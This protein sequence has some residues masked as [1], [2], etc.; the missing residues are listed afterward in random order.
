MEPAQQLRI[1]V[2]DIDNTLIHRFKASEDQEGLSSGDLLEVDR[3]SYISRK[4]IADVAG[5]LK[6]GFPFVLAT[7]RRIATYQHILKYIHPVYAIVEDGCVI[8]DRENKIDSSWLEHLAEYVGPMDE[9]TGDLHARGKL[10]EFKEQIQQLENK[11]N[12]E[13]VDEGFK[14]S[15]KIQLQID[16]GEMTG[17]EIG[18]YLETCGILVPDSLKIAVN[19]KY[20]SISVVPRIAGKAQAMSHILEQMNLEA[21]NLIALGDD[22][23]DEELLLQAGFPMTLDS[24]Q[25]RIKKLVTGRGGLVVAQGRHKGT[26]EMLDCLIGMIQASQD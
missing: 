16:I 26:S 10:W 18:E 9:I 5:I 24:A 3:E 19:S 13:L 7:S 1:V 11:G 4:T 15:F 14:A 2:S 20:N 12:F 23:N 8:L 6:T 25:E 17:D 22:Y 21:G